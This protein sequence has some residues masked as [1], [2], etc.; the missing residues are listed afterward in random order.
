MWC[1][2]IRGATI[3]ESNTSEHIL[4]ASR[5]LLQRMIEANRVEKENVACVIFTTTPDLNAAFPATAARQLGWAEVAL[6]GGQEIEVEGSLT[7]CLRI[8]V[9]LN[10]DKRLDEIV[11]VYLKGT[12][13]L[14]QGS[15]Q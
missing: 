4:F 3:V 12:E 13:V 6:L 10:T 8:L 7:K 1:R 5:E 15:E 11:H 14:R 2:G 9:L